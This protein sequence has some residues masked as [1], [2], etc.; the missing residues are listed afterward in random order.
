MQKTTAYHYNRQGNLRLETNYRMDATHPT[1]TLL[2]RLRPARLLDQAL[3][4]RRRA[5]GITPT[6][7]AGQTIAIHPLSHEPP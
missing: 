3:N 4:V 7:D 5:E 1:V 6:S 2:R